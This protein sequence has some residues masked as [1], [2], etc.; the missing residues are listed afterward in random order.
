MLIDSP[1]TF[2]KTE[3]QEDV[4]HPTVSKVIVEEK[5][6]TNPDEFSKYRFLDKTPLRS[7][8]NEFVESKLDDP[9]TRNNNIFVVKNSP[10][11]G[12]TIN[13][14]EKIPIFVPIPIFGSYNVPVYHHQDYE[15]KIKEIIPVPIEIPVEHHTIK[16]VPVI[17]QREQKVLIPQAVP[18]GVKIPYEVE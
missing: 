9:Y 15:Q 4:E 16:P 1:M 5:V 11:N 12:E 17:V 18:Y 8:T 13:T 2:L 10:D 14:I 7:P 3:P 6:V